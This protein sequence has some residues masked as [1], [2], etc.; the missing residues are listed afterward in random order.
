MFGPRTAKEQTVQWW[1]KKLCKGDESLEQEEY[2]G[3]P[4]E[5]DNNQLRAIIKA[6][7]LTTAQEVAEE[8]NVD[9]S[10]V[11]WLLKQIEMVKKL[12]KWMPQAD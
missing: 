1:F 10:M 3:Q 11:I 12:N 9:C 4:Q 5:V 8:L 2:S 7:L 6:D